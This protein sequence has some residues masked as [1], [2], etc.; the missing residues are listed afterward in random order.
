MWAHWVVLISIA[1]SLATADAMRHRYGT[2]LCLRKM[3]LML[4]TIT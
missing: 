4:H 3:T 1:L 2:T